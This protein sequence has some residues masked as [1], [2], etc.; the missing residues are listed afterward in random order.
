MPQRVLLTRRWL[1]EVERYLQDRYDVTVNEAFGTSDPGSIA[2]VFRD[3]D[4]ICPTPSE[5]LTAEVL[6][7]AAG[8]RVKVVAN[9]G[10]GVNHIDLAACRRLGI[11]VTNTPEVLTEATAELAVLLM[12]MVGRRA[13]EGE[14]K[15][16][17]GTWKGG[18][19]VLGM[20]VSGKTLGVVG[21]GRIGQATARKAHCGLGMRVLYH[22]H[23]RVSAEVESVTRAVFCASLEELLR[24][25]DFVSIHTPGGAAN[26]HLIDAPRLRQMKRSAFMINTARGEVVD[27]TALAE[28][29]RDGR[30]AGAGLD[31]YEHEPQVP[32]VFL[33][34]ENV[35]LL[36][37]VGS[38][39]RETRIAM[40]MRVAANLEQFFAGVEPQD[41]V[42]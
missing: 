42:A 19:G 30:I 2:E 5:K 25:A 17:S 8:G 15:V 34:L 40:G 27:E 6:A 18:A 16:R 39:T 38:A 10:V 11:V 28:A 14:R 31:V 20:D 37:H 1:P 3:F 22:S 12:L 23:R 36:P 29:L 33:S 32:G 24:Q 35:V 4:A 26:R 13:G 21:F 9:Y 7:A 41:R